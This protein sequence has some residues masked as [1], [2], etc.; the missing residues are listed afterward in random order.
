MFGKKLPVWLFCVLLI[1]LMLTPAA[2]AQRLSVKGK[3]A[4]IRSGPGTNYEV[5]WQAEQNYPIEVLQ[6]QGDW[7][8]FKDYENDKGWI[9]KGLTATTQCVIVKN[10]TVNV[11][12]GASTSNPIVFKAQ[13]GTPFQVLKT[14]GEWYQIKHADGDTGWIHR[15]VVW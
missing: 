4:N 15:S 1:C 8:L 7:V 2:F 6:T 12:S 5:I 13:K 3:V 11:R 9:S 14:Q 10:P